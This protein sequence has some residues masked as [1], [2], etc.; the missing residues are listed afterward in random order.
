[1]PAATGRRPQLIH[2]APNP[3]SFLQ[4]AGANHLNHL[5]P[6]RKES[7][8][9]VRSIRIILSTPPTYCC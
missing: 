5:Y 3:V 7:K 8:A 4:I 6:A 1:V 9:W 2:F